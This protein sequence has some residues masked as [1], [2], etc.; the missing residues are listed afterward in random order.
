MRSIAPR[1]STS[2]RRPTSSDSRLPMVTRIRA[3]QG[4]SVDVELELEA[5]APPDVL[6]HGTV[7]RVRRID[8][9]AG[10]RQGRAPP[11]ASVGGSRRP[12]SAVGARRGKPVV[13]TIDARQMVA[14]GHVFFRSANGVWLV[15]PVPPAYLDDP[16]RRGDRPASRSRSTTLAAC[17]AG[18]Y[19]NARGE[20]VAIDLGRRRARARVL[21]SRWHRRARSRTPRDRDLGHRRV[22][23]RGARARS[24]GAVIVACLNFASAKQPGRW[25]PR[26]RPGAGRSARA[27]ERTL[28]VPASD[29]RVLRAP[30]GASLAGIPRSRDL[31]AAR[32]VLPQPT[33]AAGSTRRCSHR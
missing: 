6:Y 7:D 21:G 3:N 13:L 18:F 14:D 26:R 10:S 23:D 4:H 33:S 32:A 8:P 17:D 11:R 1:W 22:D 30:R 25:L 29:A 12:P 24:T 2:S 16:A 15:E 20:R 31:F 27:I 28:S 5:A 19:T 9:R